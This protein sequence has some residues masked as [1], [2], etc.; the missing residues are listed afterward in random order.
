MI[1]LALV[2]YRITVFLSKKTVH[3]V[4]ENKSIV[5]AEMVNNRASRSSTSENKTILTCVNCVTETLRNQ[6]KKI[7]KAAVLTVRGTET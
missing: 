3:L 4:Q 5:V 1:L 2:Q 6:F 7:G